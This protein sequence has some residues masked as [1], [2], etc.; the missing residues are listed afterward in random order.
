MYSLLLPESILV[1]LPAFFPA[2]IFYQS[3]K[4][5]K[6]T[7]I[8]KLMYSLLPQILFFIYFYIDSIHFNMNIEGSMAPYALKVSLAS[9]VIGIMFYLIKNTNILKNNFTKLL[10]LLTVVSVI[11]F[12]SPLLFWIGGLLILPALVLYQSSEF[13]QG[14]ILTKILLSILPWIIWLIVLYFIKGDKMIVIG[15]YMVIVSLIIGCF[16][17]LINNNK[18]H[19]E[20]TKHRSQ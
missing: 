17:V 14:T 6:D 2:I 9:L 10:A 4:L 1:G 13:F 8:Y 5:F 16:T 7:E 20:T 12:M 18:V 3:T 19:K 11:F 15:I